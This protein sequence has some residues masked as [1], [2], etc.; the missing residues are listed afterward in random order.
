MR[1]GPPARPDGRRGPAA[2][3][4]GGAASGSEPPGRSAAGLTP[5]AVA[6]ERLAAALSEEQVRLAAKVE[7]LEAVNGRLAEAREELLR[8]ER[9]ASVGRLAAGIAHEVGNPLGA[10]AG[11]AELARTRLADGSA[12]R[13]P[14][15][16]FLRRIGV[17][18]GRIDAIVRDLLDFAR[19]TPLRSVRWRWR[20]RWTRRCGWPGSSPAAGG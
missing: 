17:E 12:D 13:R 1:G 3:P 5:A 4:D 7:E 11:Y 16:D 20:R 10:I 18:A 9:L 8:S 2:R 19:P 6:F 15:D 14:V